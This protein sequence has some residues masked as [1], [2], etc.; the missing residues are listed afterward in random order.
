M[1]N[2]LSVIIPAR[3]VEK[4]LDKLHKLIRKE[5]GSKVEVIICEDGSTDSTRSIAKKL[6]KHSKTIL[7]T[8]KQG[9]GK[10]GALTSGFNKASKNNIVFIDADLSIHPR[11]IKKIMKMLSALIFS[12]V[13][14]GLRFLLSTSQS[15]SLLL[16]LRLVFVCSPGQRFFQLLF[17]FLRQRPQ[18]RIGSR[19]VV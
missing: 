8:K 7:I 9:Q 3:N 5:L 10:G 17:V 13:G 15:Y 2:E 11:E 4:T 14:S 12:V 6:S 1:N 18:V 19:I 16:V